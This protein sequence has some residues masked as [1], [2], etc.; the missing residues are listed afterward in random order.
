[1]HT[2][3]V[4]CYDRDDGSDSSCSSVALFPGEASI[5]FKSLSINLCL[6]WG[7]GAFLSWLTPLRDVL[8][9]GK[10]DFGKRLQTSQSLCSIVSVRYVNNLCGCLSVSLHCLKFYNIM[11]FIDK[12]LLFSKLSLK[13]TFKCLQHSRAVV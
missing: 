10:L 6:F 12:Y 2:M 8:F 3:K 7:C 1:M 11:S 13:L 4:K 5:M 9:G